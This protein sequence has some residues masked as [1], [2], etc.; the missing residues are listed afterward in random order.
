MRKIIYISLLLFTLIGCEREIPQ[1]LQSVKIFYI[2]PTNFNSDI[3]YSNKEVRLIGTDAN[4]SFSTSEDGS[5][6]LNNIIPGIYDVVTTWEMTGEEYKSLTKSDNNVQ[7]NANIIIVSNQSGQ[8]LFN[9]SALTYELDKIEIKSLMIS[10]VYYSGTKDDMGQSYS[11]DAYV[12]IFNN[13]E[14]VEYIDGKYLALAESGS[15][16]SFLPADHPDSLYARQII[17][18]PGNGKEYPIEPGGAIVIAAR[19]ARNHTLSAATS[20]DLSNADFE[21]KESDGMGNP[22]VKAISLISNSTTTPYFNLIRAGG[23]AVFLFETDEDVLSWPEIFPPGKT[24]GQMYRAI[25]KNVVIDGVEAL[26]NEASTGPDINAKR[27]HKEID[28]TYIY[29][30][31]T[32]GYTHESVDRK[33]DRFENGRAYLIDTNNSIEDF[34]ICSDPRPKVYD[35]NQE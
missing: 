32:S 9:E 2:L 27:L 24:S 26:Q 34:M 10:K 12:E 16:A 31:A 25:P 8:R 11:V 15:P 14:D 17:K 1:A 23:N 20:V 19:N 5:V 7:D 18:F 21:V 29:I 4:Y 6:E 13:S 33:V 28:A 35:K 30:N 3:A 22:D